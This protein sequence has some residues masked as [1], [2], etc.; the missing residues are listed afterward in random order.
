MGH[1]RPKGS[2]L[3]PRTHSLLI[4]YPPFMTL[5]RHVGLPLSIHPSTPTGTL[6]S[7]QSLRS[8]PNDSNH[9]PYHTSFTFFCSMLSL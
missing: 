5:G 1:L 4:P 3:N 8:F 9:L 7:R 2:A 6:Y